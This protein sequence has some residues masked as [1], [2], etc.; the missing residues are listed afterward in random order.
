MDGTTIHGSVKLVVNRILSLKPNV[1]IVFFTPF[2]RTNYA[3]DVP[4]DGYTPT[5]NG[6]TIKNVGEAIMDE[7]R[8]L[9]IPYYDLL[10]NSGINSYNLLTYPLPTRVAS[11]A[12]WR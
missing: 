11:W 9:G 7:C 10:A 4:G 3:S 6:L 1:R 12:L 2:N 8:Y 5:P